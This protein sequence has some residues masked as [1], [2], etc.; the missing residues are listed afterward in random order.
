MAARNTRKRHQRRRGRFGFLYKLLSFLVILAAIVVGCVVFFRVNE[1][2]VEGNSR[3][4]A[5]EIIDASGV[6]LGENLLLINKPQTA[7]AIQKQ[8]PYVQNVFV[9]RRLPDGL[10]LRITESAAAAAIQVEEAWWLMDA[11]GKLLEAGNESLK[12]NLPVVSGIHLTEPGLG[13][14][15][16]VEAEEKF[17][18]ES[19]ESLLTALASR[20]MAG[21]VTGFIDL[22]ATNTIYFGFGD[23][24]TVA[25]PMTGDF[26][27]RA[28][29]LQRV[30]ETFQQRGESVSG[31]LDL[32]YGD[33]QA[34]LLTER[35]LPGQNNAGEEGTLD[36]TGTADEPGTGPESGVQPEGGQAQEQ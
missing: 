34:R 1:V 25:A 12:G 13:D 35:W 16:T 5:Q 31:T 28:F 29:Q 18:L 10:T 33:E 30:L 3:Y 11:R 4:T 19:L 26:K 24:L 17:K 32:T 20:G 21:N 9:I 23:S 7:G 15:M 6:E 22:N 14:W 8:L 27:R 2:T 36:G